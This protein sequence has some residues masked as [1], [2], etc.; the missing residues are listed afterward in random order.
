MNNTVIILHNRLSSHP[1][2][3]ELDVMDQVELVRDAL[4]KLN[5]DSRISDVGT[6]LYKDL[7]PLTCDKPEFIFNLVESVMGKT[8][9]LHVVPSILGAWKIPYTGVGEEGL[10]MT[11]R[12]PLAKKIMQQNGI[13]TPR[14]FSTEESSRAAMNKKYIV[15]PSCEEGSADLDEQHV[16]DP[17]R[18][19]IGKWLRTF[20]PKAYFIEEYIDGREFN[21]S[22]TGKPG[23]YVM[24]PIPEM[25]FCDYPPGK[26]R[27]LGYRSKWE[28]T[29]FEYKHTCRQ[30]NTLEEDPGLAARLRQTAVA[31]G[32]IF[33]LSGYFRVDVR[34]DY[35]GTPYV[36]EVNANPCISPDS[37]FIAAGLQA[38]FSRVDIIR[39]IIACLN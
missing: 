28:E 11:T 12:K 16:F 23:D 25:I 14:W 33:N 2:P 5:Y 29:S 36:L 10:F 15:K 30:F 7:L 38:G 34:V 22:V 1:T 26:A 4:G 35:E 39:Q 3:D 18:P 19:D 8:G 32:E 20:D 21:L 17:G 24:Y 27:I 9:L 37:G 31:C 13:N 6:D